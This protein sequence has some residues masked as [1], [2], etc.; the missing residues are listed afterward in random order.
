MDKFTCLHPTRKWTSWHNGTNN[1]WTPPHP[2]Y[3]RYGHMSSP[4]IPGLHHIHSIDHIKMADDKGGRTQEARGALAP[5]ILDLHTR[6]LRTDNWLLHSL[7]RQPPPPPPPIIF[8]LR[9]HWQMIPTLNR[10][11][12]EKQRVQNHFVSYE[13]NIGHFFCNVNATVSFGNLFNPVYIQI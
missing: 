13:A 5:P 1:A 3:Y 7:S 6:T 12:L 9:H 2:N 11:L 10:K 8:L 4:R